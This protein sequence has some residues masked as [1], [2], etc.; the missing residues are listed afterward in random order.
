MSADELNLLQARVKEEFKT[1]FELK[2]SVSNLALY[3]IFNT[4]PPKKDYPDYYV[5]I[6][7]PVS[8]NTLRKRIPHY[9]DV[10]EFIKD[11]AQ[12][13]WNAKTY[14]AKGSE[15]YRYAVILEEHLKNVMLPN[16]KKFYPTIIYPDLGPLPEDKSQKLNS[17][18]NN[19]NGNNQQPVQ[20]K[21]NVILTK[22][23][24]TKIENPVQV[25]QP[26]II[27]QQPS[28]SSQHTMKS[29]KV[30]IP[31]SQ[32]LPKQI[33]IKQTT[34]REMR[35]QSVENT[36]TSRNISTTPQ[37]TVMNTH[38]YNNNKLPS[39]DSKKTHVRRGRPPII[40]LPYIQRM[41]NILKV[42]KREHDPNSSRKSLLY[43]F[44]RLPDRANQPDY[45]TIITNPISIDDMWRKVKTRKY[46]SFSDFQ[47]DF[48]LMVDNFKVYYGTIRDMQGLNTLTVLE[49]TFRVVTDYELTKPDKDYIPE[50]EFRY[51]IEEITL[52]GKSYYIGDWVFLNNPNDPNK[53]IVGQIFKLWST[54]D[55]KKWLNACWYFRPEQTVHRADRLFYKN[56]VM[57]TGQ[58][59]D[60]PIDDIRGKCYVI[61]FTR[62]QRGDPD[63]NIEGPLFI[64]EFR[65]NENDKIFNKIR[66][67]KA[68]LP[69][70][71]RDLD[72]QTITVNGRKFFK[73]P[74]PIKHLLPPNAAYNDPLP[75]ARRGL[76]NAPPLV[77]A[78]YLRPKLDRDDL[79]E[80]STS[81][82]CPRYIIRPGDPQED[83][84]ID[85]V[86][87]TI[88]TNSSTHGSNIPRAVNSSSK[89]S[90]I[91]SM[92][93]L[94]VKQARYMVNGQKMK[95]M[96]KTPGMNLSDSGNNLI[97]MNFGLSNNALDF[98]T[99][100]Y[101]LIN[102]PTDDMKYNNGATNSR[103]G[104]IT[105]RH[106]SQPLMISKQQQK[107]QTKKSI[108]ALLQNLQ[109]RS[110]YTQVIVDSPSTYTLPVGIS[111]YDANIR[112]VDYG[113]L[114]RRFTK[115]DLALRKSQAAN[116]ESLWFRGTGLAI[117]ER[118][119]N[120]G[121]RTL[122]LP[123][124]LNY[125]VEEGK[126]EKEKE[127]KDFE[128]EDIEEV[129]MRV[130]NGDI[131]QEVLISTMPIVDG[132][133]GKMGPRTV[134]LNVDDSDEEMLDEDN[135]VETNEPNIKNTTEHIAGPFIHGLRS[136]SKFIAYRLGTQSTTD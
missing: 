107:S 16:L 91:S 81:D 65:Y 26:K 132:P 57:K 18:T 85:F 25:Q 24:Q 136:S 123:L 124:N 101:N 77:G 52:D 98:S 104:L 131:P 36:P 94:P 135:S 110:S 5:I 8:L 83:G 4:L 128:I 119:I 120:L 35:S 64:C 126:P 125:E 39:N 76:A 28:S 34:P 33:T 7:N 43:R 106:S 60:H 129:I 59:R 69:E 49:K 15:I 114:V 88:I 17:T 113:S 61:H 90:S 2:D 96:I 100:N 102:G 93:P 103:L 78:V 6:T 109:T 105:G 86:N 95:H 75:E 44:D 13:P 47:L 66:T 71:I 56:E 122:E 118:M 23:D 97:G 80:Y 55:G 121:D 92:N 32:A 116:N 112:T 22:K 89:L 41:K 108:S 58:Y 11:V 10:M 42:L 73:Y 51:P 30:T 63:F 27:T 53:P 117:T 68:C 115:Q 50:G 1:L 45:Y 48:T 19:N 79:G 31:S 14:N 134:T 40:D 87:G 3:P 99:S 127:V 12:I 84:E 70:E 82:D 74:S 54:P 133:D 130:S 62:Y 37:P 46:K 21:V 111:Q 20:S 38:S 67:W 72:E 29:I 9:T